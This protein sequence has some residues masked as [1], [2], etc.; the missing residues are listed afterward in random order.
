VKLPVRHRRAPAFTQTEPFGSQAVPPAR[1]LAF[2]CIT[3]D[4]LRVDG[5]EPE[6]FTLM[7]LPV[8]IWIV[9]PLPPALGRTKRTARDPYR[10]GRKR[11]IRQTLPVDRNDHEG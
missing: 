8:A 10:A 7:E 2:A 4:G 11:A 6:A 9:A 5:G 1:R 3:Q